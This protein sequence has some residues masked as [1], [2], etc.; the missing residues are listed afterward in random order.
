MGHQE[1]EKCQC[2]PKVFQQ[3]TSARTYR[4]TVTVLRILHIVFGSHHSQLVRD[5]HR[6]WS[7][8]RAGNLCTLAEHCYVFSLQSCVP[9]SFHGVYGL[10]SFPYMVSPVSCA[11]YP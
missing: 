6:Y 4:T 2:K 7:A 10:G 11:S 9:S 8:Y 5:V 1:E 3:Q